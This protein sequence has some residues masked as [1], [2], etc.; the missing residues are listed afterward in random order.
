MAAVMA[1]L[2]TAINILKERFPGR[3]KCIET[4]TIRS[5]SE[6]HGSTLVI[7]KTL[8]NRGSLISIDCMPKSITISRDIC[9]NVANVKWV[10]SDSVK[11]LKANHDKFHFA[12]LDSKNDPDFIFEEFRLIGPKI[13][14]G[15]IIIVD[16]AGVDT[17]GEIL[18]TTMQKKG[19]KIA[20]FLKSFGCRDFVRKAP[21]HGTQLWIDTKKITLK[22]YENGK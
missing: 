12:F 16:D 5:Y 11:Y 7:S 4:G 8:G 9:K 13:I 21:C 2:A 10:L 18:S 15:G 17:K 3:I 14:D 1:N 22:D 19:H 6:H 20:A